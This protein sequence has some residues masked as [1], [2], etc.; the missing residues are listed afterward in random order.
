MSLFSLFGLAAG[1]RFPDITAEK[2]THG[3]AV[4]PNDLNLSR[5]VEAQDGQ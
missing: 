1:E 2:P 5:R 3:A 4:S